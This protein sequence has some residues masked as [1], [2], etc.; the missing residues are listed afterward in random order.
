MGSAAGDAATARMAR[1]IGMLSSTP[2]S[3]T[4]NASGA[5]RSEKI[6]ARSGAPVTE[7]PPSVVTVAGSKAN[8][9]EADARPASASLST[10]AFVVTPGPRKCEI[11]GSTDP[12]SCSWWNWKKA[13][14]RPMLMFSPGAPT[15]ISSVGV[16]SVPVSTRSR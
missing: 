13:S 2:P 3:I 4:R 12:T 14:R 16:S 15:T 5:P 7:A 8:G 6:V 11:G 1:A 10:M 9:N